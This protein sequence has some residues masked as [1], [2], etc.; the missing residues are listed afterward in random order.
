MKFKGGHKHKKDRH[1][2]MFGRVMLLS[3]APDDSHGSDSDHHGHGFH[4]RKMW[5]HHFRHGFKEHLFHGRHRIHGFQ[6][7]G[8]H[9]DNRM[10]DDLQEHGFHGGCCKRRF[11]K[12]GHHK[13]GHCKRG[14]FFLRF[15]SS[16][17]ESDDSVEVVDTNQEAGTCQRENEASTANEDI[18][19]PSAP[20][21]EGGSSA[22]VVEQGESSPMEEVV[23][24]S[25]AKE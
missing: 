22:P 15:D 6:E 13:H 7:R 24:L 20:I 4:K 17:S 18:G 1:C 9:G 10:P 14:F 8:S 21:A 19:E 5:K 2:G 11:K 12:H 25:D 16:E 23:E 3:T